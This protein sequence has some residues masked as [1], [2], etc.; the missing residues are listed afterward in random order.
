MC[1]LGCR[2]DAGGDQQ[3]ALPTLVHENSLAL[4]SEEARSRPL[5]AKLCPENVSCR[6]R[7]CRMGNINPS[8]H[9]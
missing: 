2:E 6:E 3:H 9:F 1:Q 8:P 4:G 5:I 7:T